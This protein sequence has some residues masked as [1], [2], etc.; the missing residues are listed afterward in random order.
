M[1]FRN[2]VFTR[3][4]AMRLAALGPGTTGL[5]ECEG[6]PPHHPNLVGLL[7]PRTVSCGL[8]WNDVL[9][10][11]TNSGLKHLQVGRHTFVNLIFTFFKLVIKHYNYVKC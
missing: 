4:R 7:S 1:L 2:Q 5:T 10:E 11:E 9:E 3:E 8:N 6:S